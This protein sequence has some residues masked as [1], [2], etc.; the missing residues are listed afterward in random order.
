MLNSFIEGK[1]KALVVE[2][3]VKYGT[4][5]TDYNLI[6][7]DDIRFMM[8]WMERHELLLYNRPDRLQIPILY[9]LT[10]KALDLLKE[11]DRE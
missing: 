1:A 6:G 2:W 3:M 11:D 8:G 4:D 10:D 7:R 9:K 5:W